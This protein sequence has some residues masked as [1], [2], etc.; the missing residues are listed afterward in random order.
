MGNPEPTT[1]KCPLSSTPQFPPLLEDNE[2]VFIIT[3]R[4]PSNLWRPLGAK[5]ESTVAFVI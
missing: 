2:G 3:A 5:S 4:A 1:T